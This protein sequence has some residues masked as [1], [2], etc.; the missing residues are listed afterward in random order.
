MLVG[1]FVATRFLPTPPPPIPDPELVASNG[2]YAGDVYTETGTIAN[3]GHGPTDDVVVRVTVYDGATVIGRGQQDLGPLKAGAQ[4]VYVIAVTVSPAPDHIST[5]TDWTW[6][7]D[8]CPPGS[9]P[10]PDPTDASTQLCPGQAA[11]AR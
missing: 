6:Q 3:Q 11:T 5:E 8:R 1:L 4:H 7:A 9:T 2:S 10:S